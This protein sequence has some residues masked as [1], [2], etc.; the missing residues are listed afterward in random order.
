MP[1]THTNTTISG[2]SFTTRPPLPSKEPK[3]IWSEKILQP[4]PKPHPSSKQCK[5]P[6]CQCPYSRPPHTKLSNPQSSPISGPPPK[7]GIC[8]NKLLMHLVSLNGNPQTTTEHQDTAP[9][10][11]SSPNITS[12]SQS[13]SY[14]D[15][16]TESDAASTTESTSSQSTMS[17]ASDRQL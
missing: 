6:H 15:T 11:P 17:T 9:M 12:S 14:L 7:A 2:P 3:F 5:T 1:Q 13:S 10:E 8:L 16:D 4:N